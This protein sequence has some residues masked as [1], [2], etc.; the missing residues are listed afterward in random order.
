MKKVDFVTVQAEIFNK[1]FNNS[2]DGVLL[3]KGNRFIACNQA[4]LRM[5]RSDNEQQVYNT[6]PA[7]LSPEKQPDGSLSTE[8]AEKMIAL[9]YQK[10][11]HR[12]EWLH[13]RLNGENFYCEVTLTPVKLDHEIFLH[14]VWRDLTKLKKTEQLFDSIVNTALDAI[15]TINEQGIIQSFNPAACRLFGYT[16]HEL[17][18]QNISMLV[19]SPHQEK[20]DQY[21]NNFLQTGISETVGKVRETV[22][23]RKNGLQIPIRLSVSKIQLQDDIVFC[24]FI[25]DLSVQ[26]KLET[27]LRRHGELM[28]HEVKQKT[29]EFLQAKEMA[30]Q[31]N[32]AKSEFL[33]NMSHELRTPMH[34]ILSF[35]SLGLKKNKTVTKEKLVEYFQNIHTSGRRLMVLLNDLLDVAK[36]ESGKIQFNFSKYDLVQVVNDCVIELNARLLE[37]KITVNVEV[38]AENSYAEID[39]ARI[40]QVMTNLLSNAITYSPA[41]STIRITIASTK[42]ESDQPALE[43]R[44]MDYGVGIPENE[45]ESVF[46]KFIQS[47]KTKQKSGGTGL[48][49]TICKEIIQIHNGRVWAE[50]SDH[51][52]AVFVFVIPLKHSVD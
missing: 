14:T 28:E 8:K 17:I 22:A 7:K 30:E 13:C 31:A 11:F 15:V 49:L 46:D 33:A 51:S 3:L 36:L 41:K 9:A 43:C 20:H 29:Q 48:G 35:A 42:L 44:V 38:L 32:R 27:D 12:F 34:G 19:Y 1:A 40:A 45:L 25:H 6:H 26:K 24:G 21:L 2:E 18:G 50:K 4:A 37:S 16:E 39:D 5:L 23:V 52:G 47:S 10:G